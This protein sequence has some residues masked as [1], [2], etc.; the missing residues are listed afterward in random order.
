MSASL[1]LVFSVSTFSKTHSHTIPPPPMHPY[2]KSSKYIIN[3]ILLLRLR[4]SDSGYAM[5]V[6]VALS[7]TLFGLMSA[8][9][10]QTNISKSSM[11]AIADNN[12]IFYAAESGLNFRANQIR[13]RFR[14]FEQPSGTSPT[15]INDCIDATASSGS[16][17]YACSSRSFSYNEPTVLRS[18]EN[19]V[20][21]NQQKSPYV[22]YSYIKESPKSLITIPA[23]ELYAGLTAIEY[24]YRVYA[25]AVRKSSS[26]YVHAQSLLSTDL[27]SRVIPLFQFAVFYNDDLEINNGP[28]MTLTG[29]V[30]TN[31]D[32]RLSPAADLKFKGD[33]TAGG[34]IYDSIG[35][36]GG[37]SNGQALNGWVKFT[38]IHG[39]VV[40]GTDNTNLEFKVTE[41]NGAA[42]TIA[43]LARFGNR[44]KSKTTR[45]DVPPASF[46]TKVDTSQPGNIGEYYGKADFQLEMLP[47]ATGSTPPFK[48]TAIKTGMTPGG[49]TGVTISTDRLGGPFT[50]SVLSKGEL[51]SLQQPVLVQPETDAATGLKTT[52]GIKQHAFFCSATI[53]TPPTVGVSRRAQVAIALQTAIVSQSKALPFSSIAKIVTDDTAVKNSFEA[54][55]GKIAGLT[56]TEKTALLAS[57]LE[58]IASV[59]N[60]CFIPAPI[61]FISANSSIAQANRFHDQREQRDINVLQTNLHSL[62]AWNYYN[63]S[64]EW[65]STAVSND[66]NGQGVSTDELLFQRYT[67]DP[68]AYP[69]ANTLRGLKIG[70]KS[71][72]AAD[73]REGG[74]V[75]HATV[76]RAANPYTAGRSPYAFAVTKG[77][78]LPAPLSIASD[79]SIYLQGNYNDSVDKQPAAIIADTIT[80]LSNLCWDDTRGIKGP[81]TNECGKKTGMIAANDTTIK[82]AFLYGITS[83]DATND[84]YSGGVHNSM[85]FLENWGGKAFNYTGSIVSLRNSTEFTRHL[86][87]SYYSPPTRDLSYDLNFNEFKDLPPMTPNV[88]YL[89]HKGFQRD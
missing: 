86:N 79:Q 39:N 67:P 42:M 19:I 14:G 71:L 27:S 21:I 11:T 78:S 12:S 44:M 61:Q 83:S 73:R 89:K 85:R 55:L 46:T 87:G 20:S 80:V 2:P 13:R 10:M 65:G 40:K 6:T 53:P 64:V 26:G 37:Y 45:L 76:D 66:Y 38:D 25:S 72:G 63:I 52:D 70:T 50:C 41:R 4:S 69:P 17:D 28:A 59:N 33:V 15:S 16:G 24:R 54:N 77:S 51:I 60:S 82:A 81:T 75:L 58:N 7:M 47:G 62:S 9:L 74:L 3:L 84:L 18:G 31:S 35:R 48:L 68:A 5:L 56:N 1:Y 36:N 22:A 8:Y 49:C 88:I 34:E 29:R 23:Q 57:K 43:E 32:L 30:H